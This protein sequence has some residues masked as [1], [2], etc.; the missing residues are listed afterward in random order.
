[1]DAL[2]F[3]PALRIETFNKHLRLKY[4]YFTTKA[5]LSSSLHSYKEL[6][7][8]KPTFDRNKI[9]MTDRGLEHV[10]SYRPYP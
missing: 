6:P 3:L 9:H 10:Y 5:V 2:Y 1:M 7:C 4:Y 8:I